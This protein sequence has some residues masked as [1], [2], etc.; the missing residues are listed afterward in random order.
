MILLLPIEKELMKCNVLTLKIFLKEKMESGERGGS[1]VK[2]TSHSTR[3]PRFSFQL[4]CGSLQM[5]V[6]RF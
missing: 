1:V 3:R 5:S 6:T 2:S 4:L